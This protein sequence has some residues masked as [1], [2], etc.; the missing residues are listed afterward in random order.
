MQG[1]HQR[2]EIPRGS[3]LRK[4]SIEILKEEVVSWFE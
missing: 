4:D 2:F 1:V 3:K